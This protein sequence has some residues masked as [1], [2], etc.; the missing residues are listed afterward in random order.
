[1]SHFHRGTGIFDDGSKRVSKHATIYLHDLKLLKDFYTK[2]LQLV[3][4]L[5]LLLLL[6]MTQM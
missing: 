6:L 3:F 4:L 5:L 2:A 1:M